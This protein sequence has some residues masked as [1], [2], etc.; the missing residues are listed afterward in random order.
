MFD[1]RILSRIGPEGEME[2]NMPYWQYILIWAVILAWNVE[3]RAWSV[4]LFPKP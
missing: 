4:E 2:E 1:G 3:R